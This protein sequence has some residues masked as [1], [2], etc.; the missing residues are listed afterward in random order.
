MATL[1]GFIKAVRTAKTIAD[2]RITSSTSGL[3][4]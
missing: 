1:K 3:T 4:L 2:E